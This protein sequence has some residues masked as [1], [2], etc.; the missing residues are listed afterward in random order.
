MTRLSGAG[1]ASTLEIEVAST[2]VLSPHIS[3][4][5]AVESDVWT[6][7]WYELDVL[8]G[9]QMATAQDRPALNLAEPLTLTL[10]VS[11]G[12]TV[13][14]DEVRL[15]SSPRGTYSSYLPLIAYGH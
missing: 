1:P 5:V 13:L 6:H 14:V 7:V 8:A 4:S 3:Y 9:Q 12:P 2:D 15:G 10:V 11:D